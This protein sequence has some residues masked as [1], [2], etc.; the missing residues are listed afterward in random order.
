MSRWQVV[1]LLVTLYIGWSV[2]SVGRSQG[3]SK[4]P[5]TLRLS[6][7]FGLLTSRTVARELNLTDEQMSQLK[8]LRSE[9]MATIDRA[10]RL[11]EL[12]DAGRYAAQRQAQADLKALDQ[13]LTALLTPEQVKR[14]RQIQLQRRLREGA[15][16]GFL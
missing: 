6:D 3:T 10:V 2:A 12:T 4:A 11:E 15:D 13:R 9:Q 5:E 8:K 16:R 1:C 7:V 14:V